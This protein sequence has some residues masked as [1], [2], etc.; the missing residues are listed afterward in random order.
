M[1][2]ATPPTTPGHVVKAHQPVV[3]RI[4]AV[5]GYIV[6]IVGFLHAVLA[7]AYLPFSNW[8]RTRVGEDFSDDLAGA[9]SHARVVDVLLEVFAIAMAVLLIPIARRLWRG[10][11]NAPSLLSRWCLAKIALELANAALLAWQN[12]SHISTRSDVPHEAALGTTAGVVMYALCTG[13]T[14]PL[15]SLIWLRV[16]GRRREQ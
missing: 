10:D 7:I 11:P 1:V 2:P 12:W 13:L 6:G 3:R 16:S 14:Y 5:F 8:L 4:V 15:V 9:M